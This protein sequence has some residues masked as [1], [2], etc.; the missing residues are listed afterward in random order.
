MKATLA[1]LIYT[2]LFS[3]PLKKEEIWRSLIAKKKTQKQVTTDLQKLKSKGKI[4]EKQGYFFLKNR[5][6]LIS[7]RKKGEQEAAKKIKKIKKILPILK[8]L[9]FLKAIV[10]TGGVACANVKEDD[11]IDLLV[12]TEANRLWLARPLSIFLLE[13]LGIRRRPKQKKIKD[14]ICLNILLDEKALTIPKKKRNLYSAFE[15]SQMNFLWQKDNTK[16]KFYKANLWLKDYLPNTVKI[17]E[18]KNKKNK[19][20]SIINKKEKSLNIFNFLNKITY[21]IQFI[22]METKRTTETTSLHFAFFHPQDK[23]KK[24]LKKFSQRV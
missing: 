15:I 11:D 23:A 19:E 3:Y 7:K 6:G 21:K 1:T 8:K 24:V 9:P 13:I 18:K 4:Q 22:Y 16:K 2:D 20:I 12:I 14:K 10:L 5:E 17:K